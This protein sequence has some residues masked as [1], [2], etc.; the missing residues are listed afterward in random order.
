M[1]NETFWSSILENVLYPLCCSYYNSASPVNYAWT[2]EDRREIICQAV[3]TD[4][5]DDS[6]CREIFGGSSTSSATLSSVT[7]TSTTTAEELDTTTSGAGRMS[8][9]F[10]WSDRV[11]NVRYSVTWNLCLFG[12]IKICFE[13]M[14]LF[15]PR[16]QNLLVERASSQNIF[17]L[18]NWKWAIIGCDF[19]LPWYCTFS[20][21][22]CFSGICFRIFLE[23]NKASKGIFF[24]KKTTLICYYH[25]H[26]FLY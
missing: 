9:L 20:L 1:R 21:K 16:S 4:R 25:F 24:L 2:E 19:L 22:R 8:F 15:M 11:S 10:W 5:A 23:P 12:F 26:L 18:S 14:P 13:N 7:S 6:K 3:T 17:P